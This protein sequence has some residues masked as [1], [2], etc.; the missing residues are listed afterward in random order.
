MVLCVE[1]L[2]DRDID[3]IGG[4]ILGVNSGSI[5]FL[6]DFAAVNSAAAASISAR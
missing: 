3:A 6:V 1:Y 5:F 2:R 4:Y